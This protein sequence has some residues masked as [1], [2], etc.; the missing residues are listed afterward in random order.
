MEF[1]NPLPRVLPATPE[2]VH[3]PSPAPLH[4]EWMCRVPVYNF[5]SGGPYAYMSGLYRDADAKP[6]RTEPD[7]RPLQELNG[8]LLQ[9]G[10]KGQ[11]TAI[12]GVCIFIGV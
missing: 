9:L 10:G 4:F 7:G 12:R 11:I 8:Q 5:V 1:I 6:N 3:T 2:M